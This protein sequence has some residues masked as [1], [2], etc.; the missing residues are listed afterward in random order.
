MITLIKLITLALHYQGLLAINELSDALIEQSNN[1]QQTNQ[2]Q[3][4]INQGKSTLDISLKRH[5]MIL[6]QANIYR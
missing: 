1:L 4:T 2:G 6:I 3:L 5:S